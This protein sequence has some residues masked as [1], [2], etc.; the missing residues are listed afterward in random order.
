MRHSQ[1]SALEIENHVLEESLPARSPF[2]MVL[3]RFRKN[4]RAMIGLWIVS[5]FVVVAIFA[6]WIA[7]YD[8]IQQNMQKMLE[9]PSLAHPF[10]TDEFGRD[11]LSRIVYGAQIS[12]MI[13]TVGVLLAVVFGVLL[14]TIAGYFG[15][16]IDSVIMRLMDILL[17][18]PSFLLALAIVSVLGPGMVNVMIAIGIF[19]V[20]T[21]SRVARS[22]VISIKNV[23]YIEAAKAMGATHTRIIWKHILPNSFSPIIVLATL[24][25]ATAIISA[26]GLS[27]LGMG[28]QPP[29]PEWGAMLS[30]GREYLR[31]APHV[32]TIPGLAIMFVVLGFNMLG[33]GLRDA[34]DP[35]MKL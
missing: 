13:G 6:P 2:N 29:T 19:S 7:P 10:G 22:A 12:L 30:T 34:L 33:D 15:G 26:A 23:E 1:P 3:R 31:V 21:F 28:A 27:F 18:F 5:I 17:A 32:S 20:P 25:I 35:K 9:G 24:R 16:L 11:I 8:P 4:R 14:G